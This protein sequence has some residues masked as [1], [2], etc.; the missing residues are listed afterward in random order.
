MSFEERLKGDFFDIASSLHAEGAEFIIV[1]A[2]AVGIHVTPRAT[3]DLDVWVRASPE[4]ARRVH[5]ALQRFGAP[6]STFNITPAD[7]ERLGCV[8]QMGV[9]PGRIDIITQLS[10]ITFDEAWPG[11]VVLEVNGVPVPFLGREALLKN[12][13]AAARPKDLLDVEILERAKK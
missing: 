1:G 2:H 10:G 6:L 12:K 5:R 11:R 4:N 3:G 13:R 7:F 9:P 8:Y